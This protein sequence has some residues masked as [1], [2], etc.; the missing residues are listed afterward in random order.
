MREKREGGEI[1][2]TLSPAG[3]S[4]S[5]EGEGE[6][7]RC[8]NEQKKKSFS[9]CSECLIHGDKEESR[10]VTHFPSSRGEKEG[11]IFF[12]FHARQLK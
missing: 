9:M 12:S 4:R 1:S 3:K 6:I 5:A 10:I 2:S 8:P 7:V 11:G